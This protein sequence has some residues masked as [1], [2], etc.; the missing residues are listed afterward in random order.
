MVQ[1][2]VR[3]VGWDERSSTYADRDGR[4]TQSQ[5]EPFRVSAICTAPLRLLPAVRVGRLHAIE[6][7][8]ALAIIEHIK[9]T[10][11]EWAECACTTQSGRSQS[12]DTCP[13]TR[14]LLAPMQNRHRFPCDVIIIFPT[15]PLL[16][17]VLRESLA[18]RPKIIYREFGK[19]DA[20]C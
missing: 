8:N 14:Q 20:C 9:Q 17:V 3:P 13:P 19:H 5:L 2:A 15:A 12:I 1:I 18:C 11:T 7:A 16:L 10:R 6:Q 4:I